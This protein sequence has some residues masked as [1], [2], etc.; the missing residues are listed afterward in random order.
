[1]KKSI[2][3]IATAVLA[4]STTSCSDSDSNGESSLSAKEEALSAITPP[5]I[6]L[7]VLPTYKAMTDAA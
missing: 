6:N 7:T 5:Y 4:L 2:L 3:T 1:M